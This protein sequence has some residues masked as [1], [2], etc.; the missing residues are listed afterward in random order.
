MAISKKNSRIIEVDGCDFRWTV[1]Q[2]SGWNDLTVQSDDGTGR[3]L[4]AQFAWEVRDGSSLP[5]HPITP[6]VVAEAIQFALQN[7]WNPKTNGAPFGCRYE[8]GTFTV[9]VS[10]GKNGS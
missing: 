10:A 7:G 6:A 5:N 9:K 4:I 1:F 2:N 8:N 3:K